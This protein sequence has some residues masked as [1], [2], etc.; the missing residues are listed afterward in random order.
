MA[1]SKIYRLIFCLMLLVVVLCLSACASVRS[2][3][4]TNEDGTIDELLYVTLQEEE[5]V[6]A[7]YSVEEI[8][9]RVSSSSLNE[10]RQIVNNFN[11][12]VSLD[13]MNSLDQDT[14]TTLNSFLSGI[15]V[16]GDRWEDD[17][18]VIGIRF[19]NMDV[20]RYYYGITSTSTAKTETE[21]H[22]FYDRIYY[23]GLSTF[24][25][26]SDLYERLNAYY[27]MNYPNL[28]ESESNE[29]LYTY[30]TDLSRE[31]SDADFVTKMDGKY[32]HTW[33]I[34]GANLS[35][36]LVL[37]YNIANRANC[38]LTLVGVS[39]AVSGILL[40]IAFLI[41]KKNQSQK[42]ENNIQ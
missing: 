40:L 4:V 31:H 41:K 37:Y 30:T 14:I 23:Y 29:L 5:I 11:M 21:S 34:D 33:V 26:Y 6:S 27:S 15:E 35:E 16:I 36:E 8:K 39:V 22:F 24:V 38:I 3:T 2:M 9:N 1:K 28:V 17:T 32:Y 19:K 13:I 7:G 25:N 12:K 18:Y 42:P 10:A 20:Y